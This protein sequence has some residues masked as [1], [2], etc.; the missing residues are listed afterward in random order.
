MGRLADTITNILVKTVFRGKAK[1]LE[2]MIDKEQNN[3]IA[4]AAQNLKK[5][6]DKFNKLL[7][8][9]DVK[10]TIEESGGKI[11]DYKIDKI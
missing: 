1:Q 11:E 6:T 4:K 8:R 3:E 2:N 7:E 10:K 9:P 5:A